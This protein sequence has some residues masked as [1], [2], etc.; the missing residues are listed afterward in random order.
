M[1]TRRVFDTPWSLKTAPQ[2]LGYFTGCME[3][4]M[5]AFQEGR[6]P[7]WRRL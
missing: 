4:S 1:W 3:E 5:H 6:P 2:V 7:R